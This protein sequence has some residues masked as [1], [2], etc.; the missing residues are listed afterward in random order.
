MTSTDTLTGE[1]ADRLAIRGLVD[2]WAHCADR[3]KPQQQAQLFVPNGT[4]AVYL[5]D[6]AASE[7]VQRLRGHAELAEAFKVLGNYDATTHFNGQS[8]VTLD[9]DRATGETYCLAHHLW[10]DNGQRMLMVMSIRYLDTF[11]R[12]DGRWLFAE[13]Q[14]ITD[15]TDKRPST[16]E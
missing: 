9:G 14:L 11:V 12:Q 1:A 7:P 5:G 4:V 13:R 6:P 15:W 10:N 8:T 2:A 3:R 16:A